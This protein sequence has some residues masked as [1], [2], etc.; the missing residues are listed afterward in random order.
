MPF[1]FSSA[2]YSATEESATWK[3]VRILIIL[4][5]YAQNLEKKIKNIVNIKQLLNLKGNIYWLFQK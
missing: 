1:K 5:K 2:S 3:L 4:S